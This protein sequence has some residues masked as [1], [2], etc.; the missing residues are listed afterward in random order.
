ML[1]ERQ[2]DYVQKWHLRYKTSDISSSLEPKL[3]ESVIETHVGAYGL[4][5]GDKSGDLE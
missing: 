3:L 4:S 5:I 1:G 2:G